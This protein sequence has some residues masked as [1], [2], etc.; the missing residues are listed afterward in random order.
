T[1]ADMITLLMVFFVMMY[2]IS[3]VNADKFRALAENLS[4]VLTGSPPAGIMEEGTN[5]T[6]P[7]LTGEAKH[8]ADLQQALNEFIAR[9]ELGEQITVNL[10]E[11][12]LVVRFQTTV[13]FAR[14]SADL[15]P[16]ARR[17]IDRVGD[18]LNDLPNYIRVEGHTCDLPINTPQYPSNWEL[19]TARATNVLQ[20]LIS[21]C[22]ISPERLSA[23]GYG[24]YRP[25]VPNINES[26]RQ[27]NRRIDI[28]I[29]RTKYDEVEPNNENPDA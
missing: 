11:R 13:L 3:T 8:L 7:E 22:N 14:G 15:T 16:E 17:I 12:G 9:E 28:V 27:M 1:Y 19:S 20:E 6:V 26:S 2:T 4:M 5:S 23:I 18:R 10:E 25:R 29:L 21:S 24:E